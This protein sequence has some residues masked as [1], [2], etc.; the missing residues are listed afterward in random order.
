MKASTDIQKV[1]VD[2]HNMRFHGFPEGWYDCSLF[3]CRLIFG[4][5]NSEVAIYVRT[6]LRGPIRL[7]VRP[8]SSAGPP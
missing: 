5:D 6:H 8:H 7:R 1:S 2:Y 4:G 3:S